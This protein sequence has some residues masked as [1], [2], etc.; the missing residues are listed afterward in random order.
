[1]R[2]MLRNYSDLEVCE[3]L[4]FGFPIGFQGSAENLHTK[5]QIWKYKNHKGATEFPHDIN[6]Y[7][8]KESKHGAILGPFKDN[9]FQD[10]LIISPLNS[11]PK[12]DSDNRRLIM[13]LSFSKGN[14][15]ND[16]IDKNEYLGKNTQIIFPRVDDFV[17]LIKTKGN[18]CLLFQKDLKRAYRLISIDPRDYNLVSFV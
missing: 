11:V 12:K 8:Q 15:V 1:M 2:T 14:A 13:D 5:D 16:F 18:G 6:S 7:I 3:I 9:P 17:E 10:N 4:E